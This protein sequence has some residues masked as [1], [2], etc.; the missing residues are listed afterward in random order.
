METGTVPKPAA[1]AVDVKEPGMR[2]T[3]QN[4]GEY[5]VQDEKGL[6][7]R[8]ICPVCFTTC[9]ACL[10]TAQAPLSREALADAVRGRARYD[11]AL[12]TADAGVPL[13][14]GHEWED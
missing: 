9:N 1:L 14:D 10:G 8:C 2:C 7:S 3:C 13:P 11:D 6:F 12:E 5:M 4:C